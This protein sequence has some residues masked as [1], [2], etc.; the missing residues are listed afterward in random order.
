MLFEE[1]QLAQARTAL[2]LIWLLTADNKDKPL[3][4]VGTYSGGQS[5]LII[6]QLVPSAIAAMIRK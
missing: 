1:A 4:P 6:D 5:A 3:V 2:G